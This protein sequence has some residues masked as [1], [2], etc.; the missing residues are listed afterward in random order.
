MINHKKIYIEYF[1]YADGELI[2]CEVCRHMCNNPLAYDND[3]PPILKE[4]TD[5]HHLSA[6]KMGG[7]GGNTIRGTKNFKDYPENL[8]AIC[9]EHHEEAEIN[10]AF[11]KLCKIIHLNNIIK[12][13]EDEDKYKIKW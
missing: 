10:K 2:V 5:I 1:G 9:R 13:L 8:I 12:H 4:A 7:A 3:R 11:N 6:R